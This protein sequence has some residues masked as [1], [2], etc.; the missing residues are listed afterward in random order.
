MDNNSSM[1]DQSSPAAT[2]ASGKKSPFNQG[3]GASSDSRKRT[4]AESLSSSKSPV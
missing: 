1:K 2:V 3:K 4:A